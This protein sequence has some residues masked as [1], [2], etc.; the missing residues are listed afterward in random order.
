MT[1][2]AFLCPQCGSPRIG[3]TA[4]VWL[5]IMQQPTGEWEIDTGFDYEF[6]DESPAGCLSCDY[7]APMR[8]FHTSE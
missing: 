5:D 4:T 1:N 2:Y 8:S 6:N 7:C 3:V